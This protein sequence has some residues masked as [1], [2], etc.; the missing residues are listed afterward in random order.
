MSMEMNT[1]VTAPPFC[2]CA[3]EASR[4]VATVAGIRTES[5]PSLPHPRRNA[6]GCKR[7]TSRGGPKRTR[8]S[9]SRFIAGGLNTTR[10]KVEAENVRIGRVRRLRGRAATSTSGTTMYQYRNQGVRYRYATVTNSRGCHMSPVCRARRT[11][12][13]IDH[14]KSAPA[15]A[16]TTTWAVGVAGWPRKTA[17][18]GTTTNRWRVPVTDWLVRLTALYRPFRVF[19]PAQYGV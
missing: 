6:Y 18:I 17:T 19:Q 1:F 11:A 7:K 8:T 15:T 14:S 4:V 2:Y 9:T 10:K 5:G 3:G 13:T 16:L 12:H